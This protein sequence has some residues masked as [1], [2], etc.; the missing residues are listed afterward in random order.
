[1]G[2]IIKQ[3]L[4]YLEGKK[5]PYTVR[6]YTL[7]LRHFWEYQGNKIP[8][9][10][11]IEGFRSSMGFSV[12]H[13]NCHMAAIRS[14]ASFCQR[15]GYKFLNPEYIVFEKSPDRQ[16]DWLNEEEIERLLGQ[17]Q[18]CD[19]RTFRD[20]A[21]L[22][23]FCSTGLRVGEMVHLNIDQLNMKTRQLT[24]IG[25]GERVRLGFFSESTALWV[26]Q[27]LIRRKDDSPAL[28]VNMRT[29][30]LSAVSMQIIVKKYSK[31]AGKQITPHI[32]RHSYAS[33]IY[34]KTKDIRFTQDML[35]HKNIMTTQIYTHIRDEQKR[36][37][38]DLT[39]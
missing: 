22:E 6:N 28:W 15:F 1:M 11:D 9:I 13:R 19:L 16:R 32:L 14:M 5:S 26:K 2:S 24:L 38:Y 37:L 12:Y 35:G 18:P 3:F 21:L 33:K 8:T 25:K 7:W 30:R 10:Q 20:R 27:Y 29:E 4:L 23:F 34:G 31:E 36:S 39:F 17:C